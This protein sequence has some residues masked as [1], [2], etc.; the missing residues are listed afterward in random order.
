[1]TQ[2]CAYT[3]DV[4]GKKSGRTQSPRRDP[5]AT[6]RSPVSRLLT[7]KAGHEE[8]PGAGWGNEAK[9]GRRAAGGARNKPGDKGHVRTDM[10]EK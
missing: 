8:Q 6:P 10:H 4:H 9:A 1:M 2:R 7:S 5:H 3:I